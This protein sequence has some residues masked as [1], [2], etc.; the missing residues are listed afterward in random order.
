MTLSVIAPPWI[1][2]ALEMAQSPRSRKS[3]QSRKPMDTLYHGTLEKFEPGQTLSPK[4]PKL[5]SRLKPSQV[6]QVLEAERPAN[7]Q[8]RLS[9]YFTAALPEQALVVQLGMHKEEIQSGSLQPEQIHVFEVEAERGTTCPMILVQ[10]VL[11][12]LAAA[13]EERARQFARFY[14]NSDEEWYFKE[15]LVPFL[16]VVRQVHFHRNYDEISKE[17]NERYRTDSKRAQHIYLSGL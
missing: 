16:R 12:L 2:P 9:A 4:V 14:W 17:T 15:T 13:K 5:P 7:S 11:L 6:E 8:S 10:M 3:V 1:E